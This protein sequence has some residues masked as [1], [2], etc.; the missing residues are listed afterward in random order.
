[1][2]ATLLEQKT[3]NKERYTDLGVQDIVAAAAPGVLVDLEGLA[4][5]VR[6][7]IG[8]YNGQGGD[9]T[10]VRRADEAQSWL[11]KGTLTPEKDPAAWLAKDL[12]SIA[13]D[14]IATVSLSHAD[15][16]SVR[17]AKPSPEAAQFT[18][19]NIPKG[20]QPSSEYVANG[21]GSVLAELRLDDVAPVAERAPPESAVKAR[22]ATFDGVVVDALAWKDGDK[23]WATFAA[24]LDAEAAGRHIDEAQAKAAADHA[25]AVAAAPKVGEGEAEQPEPPAAPLAVRDPAQDRSERLAALEAEVAKLNQSYAGWSFHIP[26]YKYANIDK[27]LEDLLAPVEAK[28][29]K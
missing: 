12:G 19:A 5:P 8:N 24:S 6:V 1:A 18:I 11:A 22:Y 17:V 4:Q 20:R 21:L 29:A 3:A 26:A 27:S 25:A 2:G 16:K 23:A 28:P 10:F 14:R 13:A 7:V 9:G 15:G